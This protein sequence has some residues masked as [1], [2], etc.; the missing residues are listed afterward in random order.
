MCV[1]KRFFFFRIFRIYFKLVRNLEWFAHRNFRS[2]K[3]TRTTAFMLK[4]ESVY[5][6]KICRCSSIARECLF[7]YRLRTPLLPQHAIIFP[8]LPLD[9]PFSRFFRKPSLKF[10]VDIRR[11]TRWTLIIDSKICTFTFGDSNQKNVKSYNKK[12]FLKSIIQKSTFSID[13]A[14]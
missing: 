8:V 2:R 3:N 13:I 4:Y 5:E 12:T 10:S 7:S 9:L 1:M 14:R 6:I 11:W